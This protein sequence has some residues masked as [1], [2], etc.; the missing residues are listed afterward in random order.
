TER[1]AGLIGD[2]AMIGL[3]LAAVYV[4]ASLAQVAVGH[5]IDRLPLRRLYLC[6]VLAHI[7]WLPLAATA[8]GR[9]EFIARL[10]AMVFIFGAI[11]FADAMIVKYV[12]DSVRSRV[13]GMRL[14]VSFGVSSIAVW[15]L[16]PVVK[17]SGFTTLFLAMAAIAI[18]TAALVT[19]LPKDDAL[20]Q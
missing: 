9:W 7:P 19:L 15:L 5:L 3:L 2:P 6:I 13:A 10:G 14:A 8:S 1:F 18:G 20:A 12:E 11:P 17:A 16:G 4:L